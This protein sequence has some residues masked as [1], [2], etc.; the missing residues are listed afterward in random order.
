MCCV[1]ANINRGKR[2]PF[3]I[4]DFLPKPVEEIEEKKHGLGVLKAWFQH[5]E[6]QWREKSG[7]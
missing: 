7:A 6:K 5:K 3:E 2:R 1:L 4:S